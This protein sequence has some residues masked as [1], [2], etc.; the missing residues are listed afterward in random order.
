VEIGRRVVKERGWIGETD[1]VAVADPIRMTA[2]ATKPCYL[3]TIERKYIALVLA[4]KIQ[5]EIEK[6]EE[7]SSSS[8]SSSSHSN[9]SS[10]EDSSASSSH[11]SDKKSKRSKLVQSL[12]DILGDGEDMIREANEQAEEIP[13]SSMSM[14]TDQI[15][16]GQ[17]GDKNQSQNHNNSESDNLDEELSK[18]SSRSGS[19]YH[20]Y[21]LSL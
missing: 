21:C 14:I 20:F 5:T 17:N 15:V 11:S 19:V 7:S 3:I 12:V 16:D 6:D 9:E 13:M 8:S 1:H 2:V 4:K 10:S 18:S